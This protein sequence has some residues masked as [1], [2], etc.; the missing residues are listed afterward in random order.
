MIR[1][2]TYLG[3]KVLRQ[4]CE[5]VGAI[6]DEAR[7]L[8]NDLLDTM[9]EHHGAGLAAPQ[10]GVPKRMFVSCYVGDDAEGGPVVGDPFVV[11]DPKITIVSDVQK[12]EEEGCLSLPG[13]YVPVERPFDI[14]VEYTNI[15]GE[16]VT[17]KA[18]G[19]KA[20]CILHENDH[21]NGVLHIDR[22]D[23]RERQKIEHKL[24]L[25]KKK[26]A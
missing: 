18:S 11:I 7:A 3:N 22:M 15:H 21:I 24:R 23:K 8:A 2:L 16:R 13:I 5:P 25:L 17:E 12:I 9:K 6:T 4:K 26:F 1:T 20:R 14:E 19:W 10:I